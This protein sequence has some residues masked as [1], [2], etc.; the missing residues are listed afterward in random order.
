MPIS[1]KNDDGRH[2]TF[3]E[4]VVG[5]SLGGKKQYTTADG[6][7]K[8][9]PKIITSNLH[10]LVFS[11]LVAQRLS[12]KT[13]W[14][15]KECLIIMER[16]GD[17]MIETV[18]DGYP[19]AIPHVGVLE[20]VQRDRKIKSNFKPNNEGHYIHRDYKQVKFRPVDAFRLRVRDEASYR[21][22]RKEL[23]DELRRKRQV[24]RKKKKP[25]SSG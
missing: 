5:S 12:R 13:G 3:P 2:I 10:T 24:S 20:I 22:T 14:T 23:Y 6:K 9:R 16:I 21:G 4:N 1:P 11:E 19:V 18:I 15:I 17:S 7:P 25:E 8:S